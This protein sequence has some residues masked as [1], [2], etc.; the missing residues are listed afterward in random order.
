MDWVFLY[1][2]PGSGKSALARQLAQSLQK[3]L[4]DLDERIALQAGCSIP[5]IFES[6]GETGFRERER[7][8]LYEALKQPA[9]VLALGGGTLLDPANRQLVEKAGSVLCLQAPFET[10]AR[11]L[12]NDA[13]QRPLLEGELL[14]R[15]RGLMQERQSHY[16]SFP[17][18]L[19][20]GAASLA[21]AAWEAQIRLGTFH[22]SG[23]GAGYDVRVVE[24]GLARLGEMLAPRR[25]NAPVAVVSDENVARLYLEA[26]VESL[27]KAGYAATGIE[28]AAG[29]QHKN[30]AT[31][32]RLYD[33]FLE[34]KLERSS[35]VIALGG[36]VVG[37][38]AGFAA[39]TY[40]RGVKWVAVPTT[41]LAMVDASL[42]GKTG[43]DLPQGK[44]LVGAFH[45]PSLVFADPQVLASLPVEE[46][47]NGLAEALKHG[48]IADPQLFEMCQQ[49]WEDL[50]G[51]WGDLVRRAMAVKV[52]VITADPYEK[53]ER[54]LLNLGHTLGHA[55]EQASDYRVR[56]GEAVAIG[57]LAATRLAEKREIA[58][59]GLA[60]AVRSALQ[61]M[62][63][64]TRIPAGLAQERLVAAMQVDKKVRDGVTRFVLP[65]KVG[66]ARW[67]VAVDDLNEVIELAM[68]D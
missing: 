28:I 11:R 1:G 9:G 19:E 22:V 10:L 16:D 68:E 17:I 45:P 26:V 34:M 44:N 37:D 12:K 30:L 52:G 15:L 29:E 62:G 43:V 41:T 50:Q 3:P 6:E 61:R 57:M 49:D 67:G 48:L 55:V 5:E 60:Q 23:M 2:P 65:V 4:I 39:A 27:M 40:L 46:M 24:G 33:V 8:A 25:L 59:A 38:L 14:E 63:L 53:G 7:T 66:Q 31:V 35:T 56:H 21:E 64:P 58:E 32:Q 51:R 13:N 18:S 36:G 54:A 20:V 47:R 42:G